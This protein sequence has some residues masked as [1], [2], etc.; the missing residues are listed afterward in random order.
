MKA[1]KFNIG[2]DP[3]L[4]EFIQI[5]LFDLGYKWPDGGCNLMNEN[6]SYIF[7]CSDS[8][9]FCADHD[10]YGNTDFTEI[11]IDWMRTQQLTEHNGKRN[12]HER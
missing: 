3:S 10:C 11:D 8:L 2:Y 7:A 12:N 6:K 4:S 9:L 5:I 1:M